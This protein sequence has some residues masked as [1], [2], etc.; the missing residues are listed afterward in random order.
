MQAGLMTPYSRALRLLFILSAV[1]EL[2]TRINQVRRAIADDDT[3]EEF[4]AWHKR[5]GRVLY[6][7]P[8]VS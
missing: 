2:D 6:K 1:D 8:S 7:G 4:T 3:N 5:L